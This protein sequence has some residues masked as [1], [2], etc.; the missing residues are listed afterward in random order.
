MRIFI[1]IREDGSILKI[2]TISFTWTNQINDYSMLSGT[3]KTLEFN[4][5]M[6]NDPYYLIS[7]ISRM[8]ASER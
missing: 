3:Q 2:W 6:F 7:S 1:N 8:S 4:L 5:A